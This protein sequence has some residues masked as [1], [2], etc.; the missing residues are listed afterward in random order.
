M[1]IEQTATTRRV[2]RPRLLITQVLAELSRFATAQ[3]ITDILRERGTRI[4]T[5]TAYRNLQMMASQGELDVIH[6]NGEAF[7]R[8]CSDQHHHH[9][10]VCRECGRTIEIEIP[11]LEQW[12]DN[13]AKRLKYQDI[14]HELEIFGLCPKCAAKH[15]IEPSLSVGT[16]PKNKPLTTPDDDNRR[17][18]AES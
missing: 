8:E 14:A 12:I 7:Y 4:G 15:D 11:G 6:V 13:A 9:H 5:A 2:T 1:S 10:I 3:E 18:P 16:A 17:Q